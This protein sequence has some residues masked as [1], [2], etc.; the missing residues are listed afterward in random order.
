[1]NRRTFL[2]SAAGITGLTALN[3]S[4]G[5]RVEKRKVNRYN[6]YWG[7]IHCHCNI[8]YA[9]GSLEDAL[10]AAAQQLDFCAAVGHSS[11][12]DMPTDRKRLGDLIDYHNR[13]FEKLAKLWPKV[14]KMTKDALKPGKFI[15]FLSYE[16]HSMKYGDHNVYCM[17][18]IGEIEKANSIEELRDK[19]KDK[20]A[21]VIPHHIAYM[22]GYRG[23]NWDYFVESPQSPFVE[24]YSRHGCSV[25][26]IS[27]YPNLHD[28]GPRSYE[29]TVE[30][31][32]KRGFKFGFIASSDHHAGYPGSYGDGVMGVYA[33]ELTPESLWKA[34]IERRIYA[35]TGERI[36][37]DFHLNDAFMGEELTETNKREIA[38]LIEGNDFLDYVDL[39]KNGHIIRRF[40]PSFRNLIPK[41]AS[42]RAKVRIEWGW[43]KKDEFVEWFGNVKVSD[44]RIISVTPCFKGLQQTSPQDIGLPPVEKTLVS[45][46]TEKSE[47]GCSWHSYTIGNPNTLTPTTC[48]I[49]LDVEMPKNASIEAK[50]NGKKFEHSLSELLEGRRSHFLRGWLSEAVSFHRAVPEK[51]F[52]LRADYID[53]ISENPTDYYYLHIRQKNNHWAWTS[54]IWVRR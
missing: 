23:V 42:I 52:S 11:W 44:G 43:G 39:V 27:P 8:S 6:L 35:S 31:G 28:M 1:M 19:L 3:M 48:A 30:A 9:R 34:F 38:L 41:S 4:S 12:H 37:I 46:I 18:P 40:E 2:Q 50:I 21:L 25:T 17:E 24:I 22:R 33:E 10:D 36:I 51:G 26:D 49:V 20:R 54:P 7:D 32:L 53:S 5:K 45:R 16:W 15:P 47:T 13:G 29:G 14:K